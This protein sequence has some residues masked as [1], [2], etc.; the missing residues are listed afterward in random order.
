MLDTFELTAKLPT[1]HY[2]DGE[3]TGGESTLDIVNPA[4]GKPITLVADASP[5]V[6]MTALDAAVAATAPPR[7]HPGHHV[8]HPW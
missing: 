1:S 4:T 5:E 2:I 3:W 7:F 8:H 6:A